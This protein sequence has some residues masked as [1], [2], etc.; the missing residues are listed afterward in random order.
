MTL[1]CGGLRR[2]VHYR[3]PSAVHALKKQGQVPP[4][5]FLAPF[6]HPAAAGHDLGCGLLGFWP[7]PPH[8]VFTHPCLSAGAFFFLL[9]PAANQSKRA[10]EG[11][12]RERGRLGNVPVTILKIGERNRVLRSAIAHAEIDILEAPGTSHICLQEV[13]SRPRV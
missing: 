6:A 9:T 10:A 11:Q 5:G 13:S 8:P 7:T 1:E 3:R 4:K 12:E 2:P